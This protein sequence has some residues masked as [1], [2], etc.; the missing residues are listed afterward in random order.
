M[1]VFLLEPYFTGSHRQWAE[2]YRDHSAH[3]VHPIT[4]EGQFW[5]WRLQ[6]GFV[7]LAEDLRDA[8]AAHGRP[9]LLLA[10]S[11]LDLAGLL[12]LTR[13]DLAGVPALLY[14]HENQVTYPTTGRTRREPAYAF[15]N[16][17]AVLAADGVAFNSEYHREAFFAALP[18]FLGACPDRRHLDQIEATVA[19]STVLPVG[20]DLRRLDAAPGERVDP[21][22]I[23][24][25]HRWDPDK[26]PAVFLEAL[27]DL[28]SDGV[29][30]RVALAGERFVKQDEE[31]ATAIA[32]LGDRVVA[33]A[34]LPAADYEQTL[35]GSDVVVSTALQEF[36]GVSLAEAMY[37]GALP[38]VPDRL[39]YPERIPPGLHDRCLYRSPAQLRERLRS[40]LSDPPSA[41]DRRVLREQV[42]GFDW[43]VVAPRYD[44]WI[45]GQDR[46]E[47]R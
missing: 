30:F 47:R 28:A 22:L 31:H 21:P 2:G 45:E 39:V 1:R 12:A 46:P 20:M 4:H 33:A 36:F 17:A 13:H 27:L 44:A 16:W 25:N 11:M 19:K 29:D 9:D 6:G 8:I 15:I 42:A 5:K 32:A 34:H 10:T 35:L 18:G 41:A 14:M 37:A 3:Q 23:L 24:W 26:A 38:I 40:A 7:T 43:S